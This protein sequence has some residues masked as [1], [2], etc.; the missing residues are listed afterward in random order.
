MTNPP[1]W[2]SGDEAD[3][4]PSPPRFDPGA[5]IAAASQLVDW[6]T[7]KIVTPHAEHDDPSEH[8]T[9]V[10]CRSASV[11]QGLSGTSEI[12]VQT[13]D[14]TTQPADEQA[15]SGIRWIPTTDQRQELWE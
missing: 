4:A 1:W 8:P 3:D 10:L 13:A 2:F 7:E 9:C 14:Q 12:T 15:L 5:L 11:L 6:A